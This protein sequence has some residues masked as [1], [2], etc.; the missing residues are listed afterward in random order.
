MAQIR[1]VTVRDLYE[2]FPTAVR[3]VGED[4][5]DDPSIDFIRAQAQRGNFGAALAYCAY[6]LPRREAVWWCVSC[7]RQVEGVTA[8]E[9]ACLDSAE[10]WV[11][12]PEELR[13]RH[14]LDLGMQTNSKLS[15][16]W[17]ALA[18]GWSGGSMSPSEAAY[19]VPVSPHLTAQ[20]VRVAM[21]S[22]A[23]RVAERARD[24][25]QQAWIDAGVRYAMV[26]AAL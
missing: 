24:L 26:E 7:V 8:A 11:R 14:A 18:A 21:M 6:L 1:F 2:T 17:A 20:A 9:K 12:D 16:T 10:A 25:T 15:G 3:D 19:R 23:P 4:I 22:A 13:R 5:C